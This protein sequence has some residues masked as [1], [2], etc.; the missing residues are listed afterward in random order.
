LTARLS[1]ANAGDHDRFR[2]RFDRGVIA[3]QVAKFH[4][5]ELAATDAGT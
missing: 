3:E 4:Q 1:T 2:L 5:Y